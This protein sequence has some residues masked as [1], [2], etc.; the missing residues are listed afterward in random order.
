MY[1]SLIMEGR[2]LELHND[3]AVTIQGDMVSTYHR[4]YYMLPEGDYPL[5]AL[6]DNQDTAVQQEE[7]RSLAGRGFHFRRPKLAWLPLLNKG[8]NRV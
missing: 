7:K 3:Y 4:R 5:Q 8:A 2:L 6:E 1:K